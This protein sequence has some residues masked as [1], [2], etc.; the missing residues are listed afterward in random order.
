MKVS[1]IIPCKNRLAHLQETIPFVLKQDYP[2]FE[3]VV[4]DYNCPQSTFQWV[5]GLVSPKIKPAI[6]FV[7]ET[8]WSLSGARNYG[9]TQS[10]G[11]ILLFLDADAKL[12]WPDF[13]TRHVEHC[14]DGS[15]VCG[16]GFHDATGCCMLRRSAFEAAGGYNEAIKSWGM[17]DIDLYSRLENKLAQERRI[18][19]GGIE[20]IKHGDEWRNYYHGGR[21]PM[22]TNEE[23]FYISQQEFKGIN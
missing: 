13:L 2:D 8:E 3:V 17:E 5:S 16:W 21:D 18:W 11:D 19:L 7:G 23:N 1:V 22:K 9:Y 12:I 20:T 15:F 14:I 6:A 10:S 4:V